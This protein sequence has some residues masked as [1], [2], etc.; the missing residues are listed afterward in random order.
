ML[1]GIQLVYQLYTRRAPGLLVSRHT[2]DGGEFLSVQ[3]SHFARAAALPSPTEAEPS[4]VGTSVHINH[5][6]IHIGGERGGHVARGVGKQQPHA[7]HQ[8]GHEFVRDR[9]Y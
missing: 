4:G 8:A 2:C 9:H 1:C 3:L 5:A 7:A 6:Q